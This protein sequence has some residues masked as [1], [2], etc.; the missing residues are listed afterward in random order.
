MSA[1]PRLVTIPISHYCEKARWALERAEIAY[2]EEPHA[3]ILHWRATMP[4][5]TRTVPVLIA[6]GSLLK[7]SAEILRWADARTAKGSHLFPT[8]PALRREVEELE[9]HF[10]AKL[11]PATRRWAYSY[12]LPDPR[13]ALE[14]LT[15]GVPAREAKLLRAGW[16]PISAMMKRGMNVTPDAAQRSLERLRAIFGEVSMRL[17][18]GQK[19]LVGDAFTAADLT[20]AALAVPAVMAPQYAWSQALE[21]LPEG[22]QR[23]IEAFRATRAGQHV[24][25]LYREERPRHV[26]HITHEA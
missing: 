10:D 20:Y 14:I 6:T 18:A 24:L 1:L 9:A 12:I 23:E 2:A 25:R 7:T 3:P 11:G 17:S 8:D 15:P 5:K 26:P 19:Y 21:A 4:L 22:M 13:R 16:T